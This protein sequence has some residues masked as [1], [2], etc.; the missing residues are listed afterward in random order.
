MYALGAYIYKKNKT[1]SERVVRSRMTN[2]IKKIPTN[3]NNPFA[4]WRKKIK[5]R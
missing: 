1:D 2:A 3:G 4:K 5:Y